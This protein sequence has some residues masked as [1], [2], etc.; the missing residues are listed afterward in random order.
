MLGL[1]LS[2]FEALIFGL[3]LFAT[4]PSRFG[5]GHA[6]QEGPPAARTDWTPVITC[7]VIT[8]VVALVAVVLMRHRWPWAGGIQVLTALVLCV[9]TVSVGR[10]GY[11][12][13]HPEPAPF[14]SYDPGRSWTP[15]GDG[16]GECRPAGG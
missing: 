14:S 11:R 1:L 12:R 9:A 8:G 3:A 10:D 5:G 6:W 13:S 4:S 16:A 7:G 15:C 2:L